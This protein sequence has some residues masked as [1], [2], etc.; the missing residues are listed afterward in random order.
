MKRV[1]QILLAA[2]VAATSVFVAAVPAHAVN[3][4]SAL[5]KGESL[6]RSTTDYIQRSTQSGIVRLR[7]Q[8]D[9][10]LV[11][12]LFSANTGAQ[13]KVCWGA[14]T[15][16]GGWKAIYQEDGNFVV[17]NSSGRALW[18]SNT[19]GLRGETVDMASDGALWVGYVRKTGPCKL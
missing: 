14:A 7:M 16:P 3:R 5:T 9:G 10:N 13:L 19:V 12:A 2:A 17:Y 8:G 1:I 6:N 18:A 4:G 11:L 15:N